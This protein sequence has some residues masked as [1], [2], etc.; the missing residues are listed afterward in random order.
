M[1]VI[2]LTARDRWSD[3]VQ[4]FDAGADDYVTKPFHMEE[5]LARVRALVLLGGK[6]RPNGFTRACGRPAL[7]LPV[8]ADERLIDYW[9]RQAEGV[10]RVARL[11]WL[12]VRVVVSD[13]HDA[14][15]PE[16][17]AGL[18]PRPAGAFSVERDLSE[19]RGTGGVLR[20]LAGDYAD[21]DV[22]LVCNA[23]QVLTDPLS[24]I[25]RALAHK[26][27]DVSLVAH[28]DGTPSGVMLLR[29]KTLRHISPV[30]YVDMKEQALPRI[31][32]EFSVRAVR[33]RRPTG[34]P[35]RT[36]EAYLRGLAEYHAKQ[37]G[38]GR[39]AEPDPLAENFARTFTIVEP[40]ASVHPTAYLHDAVVLAGARVEAGATVVR[41]VVCEGALVKREQRVV[42]ALVTAAPA[43][44][45]A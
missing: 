18:R 32:R 3:K 8:A 37:S 24:V 21:D 20:D 38:R 9:L 35:L 15:D 27:G 25:A 28:D 2:I 6:V 36:R 12:P 45:R 5:L 43:L 16:A 10:A 34:I 26:G 31:A 14:P 11:E 30:G 33:C 23:A 29:A 1:P 4:G 13:E 41:G 22:L 40:G 17:P 39:G 42:D 44:A 19:Y 7:E